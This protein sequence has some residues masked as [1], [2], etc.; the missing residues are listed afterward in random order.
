MKEVVHVSENQIMHE[1]SDGT[2]TTIWWK[3]N[4][5]IRDRQLLGRLELISQDGQ[6]IIKIEHQIDG[7]QEIC[8]LITA[9]LMEK[10]VDSL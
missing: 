6:R 8:E 1:H 9:K 3:E 5:E 4:F 7:H 2:F 10:Q